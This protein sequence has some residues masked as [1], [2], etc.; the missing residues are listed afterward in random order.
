MFCYQ[1]YDDRDADW[2]VNC[3]VIMSLTVNNAENLNR[4]VLK[5]SRKKALIAPNNL[6]VY[7]LKTACDRKEVPGG[8]EFGDFWA[9]PIHLGGYGS[10]YRGV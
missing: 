2:A 10:Y 9:D 5:G 7:R 4:Q 8:V 6:A 3:P 1:V